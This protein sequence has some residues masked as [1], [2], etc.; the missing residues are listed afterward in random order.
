MAIN[1]RS[2]FAVLYYS[3]RFTETWLNCLFLLL[4]KHFYIILS[5]VFSLFVFFQ[6]FFIC[7]FRSLHASST[8]IQLSL[9]HE[10]A[11][12]S[13]SF[14]FLSVISLSA[15]EAIFVPKIQR[16]NIIKRITEI[17]NAIGKLPTCPPLKFVTKSIVHWANVSSTCDKSL[18]IFNCLEIN[19]QYA[20]KDYTH[21][22]WQSF[23]RENKWLLDAVWYGLI[24]VVYNTE[25]FK[26]WNENKQ[27]RSMYGFVKACGFVW[28]C[29]CLIS[30]YWSFGICKRLNATTTITMSAWLYSII[31]DYLT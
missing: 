4:L 18:V 31:V 20:L 12:F 7:C 24:V 25:S 3:C 10:F 16:L 13:M 6:R 11:C 27:R 8:F 2:T 22:N 23:I 9:I 29:R 26:I 21:G 14:L 1:I 15:F 17:T 30:V 28:Q 5:I 19:K